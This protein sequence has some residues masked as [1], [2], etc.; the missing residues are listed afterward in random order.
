MWISNCVGYGN[1]KHFILLL[2]YLTVLGGV[3][4]LFLFSR[5][6]HS[7]FSNGER[8]TVPSVLLHVVLLLMNAAVAVY[9]R[10]YLREQ[11]ESIDTNTTLIETYQGCHGDP[12]INTFGQVFGPSKFLWFF[13]IDSSLPPDYSETVMG[14][15]KVR[16][17]DAVSLGILVEPALRDIDKID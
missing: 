10:I 1:Q 16:E 7:L 9:A 2:S 12:S 6:A 17:T 11:I 14:S 15:R 3:D 4:S 5:C 8:M 13:P